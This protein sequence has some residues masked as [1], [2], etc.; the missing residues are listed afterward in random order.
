MIRRFAFAL[1]LGL[2]I[3]AAAIPAAFAKPVGSDV[4]NGGYDPWAYSLVYQSTHPSTNL[5]PL[6]PWAYN[7]VHKTTTTPIVTA[8]SSSSFDWSDAAIGAGVSFGAALILLASA[9]AVRGLRRG[10]LAIS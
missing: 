7:L 6:D 5:G 4:S 8:S 10:G 1:A 2:V 3:A 9:V